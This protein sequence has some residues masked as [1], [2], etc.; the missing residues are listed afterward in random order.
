[1]GRIS[2]VLMALIGVILW[3][4]GGVS[5]ISVMV[6]L[7]IATIIIGLVVGALPGDVD[8]ASLRLA[9]GSLCTFIKNLSEELGVREK[10]V[11]IPPCENLPKGGL[12]LPKSDEFSLALG[13][14]REGMVFVEGPEEESGIL[15]SPPPGW[16]IVEYVLNN[17]GDLGG[18]GWSYSSKAVSAALSALGIGAARVF[19]S[20]GGFEVLVK[21][22]CDTPCAD[23]VL[24][25]VLLSIAI[26][27]GELL[28]LDSVE[29][30]G[31][32]FKAKIRR[33]GGVGEWL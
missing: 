21:P 26:G 5:G 4:Y 22:V 18:A 6:N 14:F 11:V 28:L 3:Y 7:G 30:E 17:A 31:G 24:V 27:T 13:K 25:S 20:E 12:F 15:I 16:D 23:P 32:H 10:A 19:E 33:L 29:A 2:G 9:C 1:M 8:R